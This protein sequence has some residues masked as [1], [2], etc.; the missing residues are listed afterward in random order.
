MGSPSITLRCD[1]GTE[2]RAQ[3][4]ERWTCPSCERSYDTGRIPKADYD[5]IRALDRRY[6][7]ISWIIVGVMALIVLAV[8][9][10]LQVIPI[11]AGLAVTLG[12]WFLYVKPIVHR[13]HRAAVGKLTRSWE[14]RPE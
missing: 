13:R 12:G 14:L 10:T 1:C 11:L 3:F 7:V 6:R 2:G 4:G 5:A 8:A 9:R